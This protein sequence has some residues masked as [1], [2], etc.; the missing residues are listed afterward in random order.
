MVCA[1]CGE[2]DDLRPCAKCKREVCWHPTCRAALAGFDEPVCAT[3]AGKLP[4]TSEGNE[5]WHNG[6]CPICSTA[7]A[8]NGPIRPFAH[9][10]VTFIL[11]KC[12]QGHLT[13]TAD[14]GNSAKVKFV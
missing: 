4:E 3:C 1:Y 14:H 10:S 9:Q 13:L 12:E 2:G 5:D 11:Y 7:L 8:F 6:A